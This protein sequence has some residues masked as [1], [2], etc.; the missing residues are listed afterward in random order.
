MLLGDW[1]VSSVTSMDLM[2]ATYDNTGK[3]DQDL[4]AW[5]TSSVKNFDQMFAASDFPSL[6]SIGSWD[7]CDHD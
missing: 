5:D 2:L 3:F 6:Q 7:V 4:S 1:D